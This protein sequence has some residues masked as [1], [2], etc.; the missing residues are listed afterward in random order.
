MHAGAYTAVTFSP[1]TIDVHGDYTVCDKLSIL[2]IMLN[3]FDID[4]DRWKC[5]R[6]CAMLR[7]NFRGSDSHSQR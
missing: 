5:S 4:M 6:V 2:H 3:V 1:A 7:S